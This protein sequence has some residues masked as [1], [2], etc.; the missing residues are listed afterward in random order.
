M[1]RKIELLAPAKDLHKAKTAIRYG[2]DAVFI[3]G[4]QYSLRSRASNFT[5]EDMQEAV[6]FAHA[7]GA[8]L[9]VTL[10]IVFHDEDMPGVIFYL[11]QLEKMGVDAV[12]I[13]SLSLVHIGKKYAPGL[14]YHISTQLSSLNSAAA[15]AL[16]EWGADRVVLGRETSI[17]DV[18]KIAQKADVPL[19]VFIHGGMCANISGRCTLSN[20][21]TLRDANRGGCAQSCR[22]HYRLFSAKGEELSEPD[23]LFS[24]GSKDLSAVAYVQR[25]VTAGI[26]SLKIEGRMKSDYYIATVVKTY[27]QLLDEIASGAKINEARITYYEAELNKAENRPSAAGFLDGHMDFSKQLYHEGKG[28]RH[29]YVAYVLSYNPVT[30]EAFISTRNPFSLHDTLEAFGPHLDNKKFRAE[31]LYDEERNVITECN[32]PMRQLYLKTAVPLQKHDM[33]RRVLV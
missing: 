32:N 19:E 27:R 10:N 25:M 33:I 5:L 21:M 17:Y 4:K 28:V 11:Q 6:N 2:A 16:Q 7:Y 30:Q 24:M 23:E 22:W 18:E 12:I 3:G 13:E 20:H 26:A 15:N 31:A 9:Y 29:D 1:S 8:K 14:E